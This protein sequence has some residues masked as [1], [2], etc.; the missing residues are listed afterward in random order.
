MGYRRIWEVVGGTFVALAVVALALGTVFAGS[1][2]SQVNERVDLEL[3]S[4]GVIS[5]ATGN[6]ELR[7]QINQGKM[8]FQARAEAKGLTENDRFSLCVDDG[9]GVDDV[10]DG[11]DLSLNLRVKLETLSGMEVTIREGMSCDGTVVLEGIVP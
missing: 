5:G 8:E 7:L 4:T 11:G 6:A 2:N 3:T 9:F 10:A 1:G